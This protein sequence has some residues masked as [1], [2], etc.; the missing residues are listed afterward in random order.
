MPEGSN[1][2]A[3]R[4]Q[5]N[6]EFDS[7]YLQRS[8]QELAEDLDKVRGAD[9]FKADSIPFLVHAIQQGAVQFNQAD[10]ERVTS[11]LND[12]KSA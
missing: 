7:Y 2:K 10:R 3:A 12:S 1:E 9:D 6:P 11:A 4:S 8:T 5:N